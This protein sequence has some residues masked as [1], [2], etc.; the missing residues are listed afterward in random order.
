[1]NPTPPSPDITPHVSK[2]VAY[3]E[4]LTPETLAQLE[5]VYARHAY[6]KDPFNEVHNTDGIRRIF[7][8]M[9][10]SLQQPRFT[11]TNRVVQGQ[12]CFLTWE[13]HFRFKRFHPEKNQVILGASHLRFAEN[14]LAVYHRDYWDAAEELYEK[15][16]VLGG[17]MR[18]IKAREQSTRDRFAKA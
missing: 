1:M 3:F 13:F 8:H 16:P 17:L 15:I 18:W 12:Q 14:G 9:F 2:L 10:A 11:V 6:F 4:T 7:E 5:S